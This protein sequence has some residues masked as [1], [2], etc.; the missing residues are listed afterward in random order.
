[1]NAEATPISI[2]EQ[3]QERLEGLLRSKEVK[4]LP[5]LDALRDELDRA[6]VVAA[7]AI[8]ADV[9]TMNS[10]V[11][12]IDE[13]TSMESELSLVYPHSAGRAGT[14]SVLAPV[15]SALLGLSVGQSI[16]WQTPGGKTLQLKVIAVTNQ[17]EAQKQFHR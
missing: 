1:M 6:N 3:D 11:R 13:N 12:F 2:T 16:A 9:V 4:S 5:G 10:T 7:N 15:G 8:P 14:V 17:P